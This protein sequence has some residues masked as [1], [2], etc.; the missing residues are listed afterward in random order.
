MAKF[1][2]RLM[3]L[4]FLA[5]CCQWTAA[6]QPV[7]QNPPAQEYYELRIYRIFDFEK[8]KIAEKHFQEALLPA[9]HRQGIDRVG[10]FVNQSD[11]NDHSLF[12]LIPFSTIDQ[13][14]NLNAKLAAD[15]DFQTASVDYFSRELADPIFN[16]IESRFM[17]AF[18]GMPKIELTDHE[19]DNQNRI[20][21][22]RLYESHTEDHARRKVQMF[23]DGEIQVMR[24]T[25]LGPVF[26]GETLIG[27]DAP[28]LIYMLSAANEEEHSQH[29]KSFLEHP[30]W[31]RM[32]NLPE[33]KDTVSKIQKWMLK[34]TSYSQ[35]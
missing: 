27:S 6:V 10:V 4:F 3:I 31:L 25:K 19:S 20:F 17:K 22:L 16:R 7:L 5:G 34:P 9:L 28:N 30:E 21:E 14:T 33:F 1:L 24:D 23:N 8:Q 13:F 18:S 2:T 12:V 29:W 15:Q 35:L 32:K 11:E 26:Y